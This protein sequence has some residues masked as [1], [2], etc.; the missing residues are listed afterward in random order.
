MADRYARR[1]VEHLQHDR[2]KPAPIPTLAADLGVDPTE[3]GIFG[4]S[5]KALVQAG[6]LEIDSEGKVGLPRMG[7]EV[8]GRFKK[9]PRGFGFVSPE[10]AVREGDVFI[11]PDATK[12]ALTGDTV[13]VKITR[14]RRNGEDDITGRIVE[15]ISRKRAKFTGEL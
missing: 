8:I 6:K 13:R 9:N 5:V 14:G 4:Q 11:P 7:E 15:V 12:D 3:I 2:Y 10:T 1:I